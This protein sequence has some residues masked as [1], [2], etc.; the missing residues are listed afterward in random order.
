MQI[1]VDLFYF[2]KQIQV[3]IFGIG[4]DFCVFYGGLDIWVC[5]GDYDFDFFV[6]NFIE[7]G[8]NWCF[9]DFCDRFSL[10]I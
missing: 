10:L 4:F 2:I 7:C 9:G 8:S 3:C 5:F 6:R 1:C